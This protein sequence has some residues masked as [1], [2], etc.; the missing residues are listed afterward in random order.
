[1][2]TKWTLT[3]TFLLNFQDVE[4][5]NGTNDQ[6]SVE[7]LTGVNADEEKIGGSFPSNLKVQQEQKVKLFLSWKHYTDRNIFVYKTF[8]YKTKLVKKLY[9][10]NKLIFKTT[11]SLRTVFNA[12]NVL[13]GKF[14]NFPCTEIMKTVFVV[15]VIC[16]LY[17]FDRFNKLH[18]CFYHS[19]I[20]DQQVNIISLAKCDLLFSFEVERVKLSMF[21]CKRKIYYLLHV[22]PMY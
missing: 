9:L 6:D 21:L 8:S 1:M 2:M 18:W 5:Q 7:G 12:I 14:F 22:K 4:V 3:F 13:S 10:S 16:I 15:F 17:C 19:F 11:F 20:F